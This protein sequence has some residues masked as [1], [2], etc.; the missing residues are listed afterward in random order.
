[1]LPNTLTSHAVSTVTSGYWVKNIV[2]FNTFGQFKVNETLYQT[3]NSTTG[4]SSVRLVFPSAFG[5]HIVGMSL[6][7]RSNNGSVQ[8]SESTSILNNKTVSITLSVSPGL[9]PGANSSITLGFY[10]L[11]TFQSIADGN[12]TAPILFAPGVSIPLDKIVTSIVLPYLTTHIVDPTPMQKAGFSHTVGTNA[13]LETWD[14]SGANVSN[15]VRS[16]QVEIFST[17]DSSGALDF[18]SAIRQLSVAANGQVIVTD[19]LNIHNLGENTIYSLSYSPLTNSSSL[20]AVPTSQPPLSNLASIPISGD[21]LN[22]NSTGQAIQPDSA[23]SLVYQYPLGQQY[24]NYSNGNYIVTIPASTPIQAIFD[25]YQ[26]ASSTVPGIVVSG[27]QLSLKGFN[28]TEIQGSPNLTF[29]VGIA[30]AFGSAL[31]IAGLLFIAVFVGAVVFRPKHESREDS[32]TTFDSLT[33]AFEDKVSN[34]NEVLSELKAKSTSASRNEIIVARS[35]LDDI[36]I[37]TNSR[38]GSLRAQL[39]NASVTVQSDLNEVLA[40]DRE[41]DRVVKDIL[42]NYDQLLSRKMKEETF[43][44]L[45]QSNE[46][47]LQNVMNSLLDQIH[48]LREEYE[49]EG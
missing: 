45:Q 32:T 41:F 38:I 18:T 25:Q 10:V 43:S 16:G 7:G 48:D 13:T 14:Y 5:G 26:I 3:T 44:R 23:A 1:M 37:K 6:H 46:R 11:N 39:A 19:T 27:N 22:L 12:Y 24:W 29:R 20:T 49:S 40:S 15:A 33:K 28:T 34:T 17:P 47:R 31:P 21:V 4:L 8:V 36:R 2:T 42:N 35:R 30:S 9:Q